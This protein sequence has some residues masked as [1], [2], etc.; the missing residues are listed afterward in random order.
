MKRLSLFFLLIV[1]GIGCSDENAPFAEPQPYRRAYDTTSSDPVFKYVS[2]YFFDYGK[3]LIT[4]VDTADYLYNF[5]MKNYVLLVQPSQ[6]VEH[7]KY[8][9]NIM[10][11]VL[12]DGYTPDFVKKHFPFALILADGIWPYR[13]EERNV[14]HYM[15]H[16]FI[17]L[18]VGELTKE[19][20]P[21][22]WAEISMELHKD[23]LID[24]NYALTKAFQ[25]PEAFLQVSSSKYGVLESK[26]YTREELYEEG[27]WTAEVTGWDYDKTK[28]P[29]EL[30][31]LR[32]WIHYIL[33][34]P[35]D[36]IREIIR[37]HTPMRTKF[38]VFTEAIKKFT[39]RDY[40]YLRFEK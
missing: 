35:E 32:D 37:K 21:E 25:I 39:G 7:L 19:F 22:K 26:L 40:S 4:D 1:F 16:N 24:Y 13:E 20:S 3:V 14:T 36:E 9:I 11:R 33:L 10:E 12:L 29:D 38:D 18:N 28:F 8:G 23:L 2:R 17:A 5:Q 31:D 27:F 15:A 34:T 6:E 30:N